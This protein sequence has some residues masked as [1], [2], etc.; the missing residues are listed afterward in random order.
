M[1]PT[2]QLLKCATPAFPGQRGFVGGSMGDDAVIIKS[3]ESEEAKASLYSTVHGAGR[4]LVSRADMMSEG[5]CGSR[6]TTM[7]SAPARERAEEVAP[8]LEDKVDRGAEPKLGGSLS[9][10]Y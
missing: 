7:R 5:S 2:R 9:R 10:D 3:V 1:A 8:R 4:C 6:S